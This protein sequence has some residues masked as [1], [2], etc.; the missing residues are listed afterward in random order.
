VDFGSGGEA[1]SD[2][3]AEMLVAEAMPFDTVLQEDKDFTGRNV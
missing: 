1:S 2:N 3:L